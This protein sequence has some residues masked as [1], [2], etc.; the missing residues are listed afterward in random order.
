MNKIVEDSHETPVGG[1]YDVL[2]V[3]GGVAGLA[4]SIA[5]ARSGARTLLL[6]R[7]GFLGGMAT[8]GMVGAFCGFFTPGSQKKTII[9]GIASNLLERLKYR[10]GLSE[11]RTS[12]V[13]TKIAVYHYNPE[14]FKFVAEEAAVQGGVEL[15]FHTLVV[16]VIWEIKGSQLSGVIVENK[17]GRFA[18]LSRI[19]IDATGDGDVAARAGAPYEIGDGKGTVQS[20]TTMFRMAHVDVE[21]IRDL[22]LQAL[23]NKLQ[24]AREKKLFDFSRT[25][26]V[27]FHAPPFGIVS[28]NITGIPN[29]SGIDAQDLTRAEIEGRRQIFQYL[30]FFRAYEAGFKDAEVC[31]IAPQV[32]VRET[33]RILGEYILAENDVL[34]GKKFDDAIAMG[35]WP[36]EFHDP[37]TGRIQWKFLEKEDDYYTIPL[38][39][40]IPRNLDNLLVAGRCISASHIAQASSRVIGQAL[41]T[42]EA[43]GILASQSANLKQ[44]P[45]EIDSKE[46]RRE[47]IQ[48]GAILQL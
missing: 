23:R 30:N 22:D 19:I 20:M 18:F 47:L 4:A 14:V 6:E 12:K 1:E 26:P 46:I 13:N 38:R 21:K 16:D 31:C 44:N 28:A 41:A 8:A 2:V 45:R 15:L 9:G 17:S 10:G 11:K 34:K 42:G 39:C 25:D 43:A 27:V 24:E 32:G 5:A 37:A 3:G 35:A 7:Y 29:L 48:Q 36:V 33:R 40:L